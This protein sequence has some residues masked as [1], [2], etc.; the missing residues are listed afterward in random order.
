MATSKSKPRPLGALIDELWELREAKRAIEVK[1]QEAEKKITEFEEVVAERMKA[2]E[3]TSAKGTKASL[4]VTT[5]TVGHVTDWD[6]FW[7]FVFRTK[8]SHLL[9]RRISDPAFREMLEQ[10]RQV[11]GVEPFN[12]RRLNLKTI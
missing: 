8:N 2:E 6:A 9:Q 7:K 10:G 12:K 3:A 5:S 4:S 1:L 11:P